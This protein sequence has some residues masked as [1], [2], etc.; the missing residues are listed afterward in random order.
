MK[1][2]FLFIKKKDIPCS[3]GGKNKCSDEKI[4]FKQVKSSSSDSEQSSFESE[5]ESEYSEILNDE[6][7]DKLEESLLKSAQEGQNVTENHLNN[8]MTDMNDPHDIPS[9]PKE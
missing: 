6:S 5:T 1:V 7:L 9:G 2:S 4:L 3:K 8:S